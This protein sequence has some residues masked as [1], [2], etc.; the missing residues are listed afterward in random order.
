MHDVGPLRVYGIIASNAIIARTA[1][2]DPEEKSSDDIRTS[3]PVGEYTGV[4]TLERIVQNIATQGIEDDLLTG[5][6]ARFWFQR[7]EAV[8]EGEGL[9]FVPAT[10]RKAK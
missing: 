4:V 3:L 1:N 2:K 6:V 10:R 8:I 5:K 7:V 9:R